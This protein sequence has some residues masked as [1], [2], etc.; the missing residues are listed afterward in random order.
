MYIDN[1]TTNKYVHKQSSIP[2]ITTQILLTLY[3]PYHSLK[4]LPITVGYPPLKSTKARMTKKPPSVH[5]SI[6]PPF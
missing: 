5:P 1:S 3:F 4:T 2:S 6:L